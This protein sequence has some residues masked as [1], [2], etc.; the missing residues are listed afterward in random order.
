MAI[1]LIGAGAL[2]GWTALGTRPQFDI[3][4]GVSTGALIA[5]FAFLGPD[6]DPVIKSFYT[7]FSTEDVIEVRGIF[8]SLFGD[9]A[10]DYRGEPLPAPGTSHTVQARFYTEDLAQGDLVAEGLISFDILD[11]V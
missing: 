10:G 7:E 1:C 9:A 6:Y 8:Q 3:V 2:V 11:I 5:P 4:T